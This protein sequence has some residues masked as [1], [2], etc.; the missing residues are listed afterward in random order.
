VRRQEI[1]NQLGTVVL[2]VMKPSRLLVPTAKSLD[3]PP[4]LAD[5]I[6]HFQCS[7]TSSGRRST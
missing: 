1:T 2:D 7:T 5:P 4:P 3:Q 6:D